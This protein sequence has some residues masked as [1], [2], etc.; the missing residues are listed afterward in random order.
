MWV[1]VYLRLAAT[2]LPKRQIKKEDD[3]RKEII[4]ERL[5]IEAAGTQEERRAD[6]DE[7]REEGDDDGNQRRSWGGSLGLIRGEEFNS[8]GT[9]YP[10]TSD[11]SSSPLTVTHSRQPVLRRLT[12]PN[13]VQC[14]CLSQ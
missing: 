14:D 12:S 3:Q 10:V 6:E 5:V 1:T 7:M 13:M 8:T 4:G 2:G 11:V 9:E